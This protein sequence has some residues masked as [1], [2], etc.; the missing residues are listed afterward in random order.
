MANPVL[1]I[2]DLSIA[3]PSTAERPLAVDGLTL[4]VMSNEIVCIVGESGSGKTMAIKAVMGLLPAPHVHL[5]GGRILL[6]G[7][8]VAGM[9]PARLREVR[10]PSV[11]MIFQEP[12]TALNPLMTVGSQIDEMIWT[13]LDMPRAKRRDEILA[14]FE[15]VELPKPEEIYHAYPHQ[16]SGG[17]R[18]RCIIAM[19]LA[20]RP[21]LLVADEPT[22]ALDVTTQAQI[23]KLIRELQMQRDTG[24]L[25][26]THDFGVVA[27]IADRVG[28]MREGVLVEFGTREEVLSNPQHPYTRNLISAVPGLKPREREDLTAQPVVLEVAGLTKSF[29]AGR[30]LFGKTRRVDAVRDVSFSVHRG[31]DAW[32][33]GRIR[34]GQNNRGTVPDGAGGRRQWADRSRRQQHRRA[35]LSRP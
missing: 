25:F 23:L 29:S 21:K 19:A 3:L 24:I 35:D 20:L 12:M 6:S 30:R 5:V 8:D 16:L 32:N 4:D 11:A 9:S 33:S 7:E 26:I 14:L 34:I 22:T 27:E 1:S 31:G 17:Q 10:G 18:Q 13:H 15:Q 2:R 28:V